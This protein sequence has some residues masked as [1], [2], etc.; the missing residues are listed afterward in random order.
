MTANVKADWRSF[1]FQKILP[2]GQL[3]DVGLLS[4]K[5]SILKLEAF[6]PFRFV[7]F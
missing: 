5:A 3:G 4:N 7:N 2:I 1:L 6:C